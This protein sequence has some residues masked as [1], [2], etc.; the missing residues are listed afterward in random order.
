MKAAG[1]TSR[2]AE[3][4]SLIILAIA[5]GLIEVLIGGAR[6][7]FSLP[8]YALLAIVG[9]LALFSL[10]SLKP[11][12][13]QVCLGTSLIFFGY[14]LVRALFSPVVYVARPDIYCVLSGLIV[15]LFIATVCTSAK[16]RWWVLF[17]LFGLA[18]IHVLVGVVQFRDGNNFMPISFLQRY[19]YERRASGLY[20]CPNHLAGLLEVLGIFGISMVCW[21]RF[22]TWSK[23]LIGYATSV[24]YLGL[25]LTGSRGGFLSAGASLLVFGLLSLL[26]LRRSGTHLFWRVGVISAV[27]AVIVGTLTLFLVNRS[28][29]LMHR[30]QNAF[31]SMTVRLDMW[32]AALEQWKT[33]PVLGT[34]SGTYLYY[35]RM[36]R[37]DRMQQDPIDVH[38]D[39]LHLLAEYGIVGGLLFLLFLGAHLHNGWKNF[40]RLGPKRVVVSHSLSSNSLALNLGALGAVTAYMVHSFVDFNL[41]IPANAL[42]LAFVFGLLANA[43]ITRQS[44]ETTIPMS[45]FRWRA[46]LPVLGALLGMQ[47]FQLWP[48]E[49]FAE[50]ARTAQ[51][52]NQPDAAM[53]FALRG[54]ETERKNPFLYQYLASAEFTRCDSLSESQARLQCYEEPIRALEM[55]RALAPQDRT[56]L[57]PLALGYDALGRFAEAEWIFYEALHLDPKS[58]YLPQVYNY[59]LS[60]WRNPQAYEKSAEPEKTEEE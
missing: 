9:L 33:R 35:G 34:G 29:F 47:C 30:A 27:T 50:R 59:H 3:A 41:H 5:L 15:Y 56:L 37:T 18:V 49:Y 21:S 19:D 2:I 53:R 36:F 24:C 58:I 22:P 54:L 25:L 39:Y 48:G 1:Q 8:S 32:H 52:D 57:V 44:D 20:V 46:L 16:A 17:F 38:N 10:R 23:L 4:S 13:A 31:D 26:I 43:G 55:A 12:P 40:A 51:K 14:I 45:I 11:P 28:D 7:V 6:L 60:R 42:L